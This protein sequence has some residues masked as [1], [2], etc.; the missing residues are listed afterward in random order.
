MSS[1]LN[2]HSL[3][4]LAVVSQDEVLQLYLNLDPLLVG[5]GGPD[6]VRLCHCRL[7]GLQ[8]DLGAVVVD[9]QGSQDQNETRECLKH[10]Q[11]ETQHYET[12]E[13]IT[14]CLP[15]IDDIALL[16]VITIVYS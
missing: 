6:V 15:P 16:C 7:V 9:M 11:D 13:L 8:D 1:V 14:F 2:V 10:T 4:L 5:E 12:G 3:V